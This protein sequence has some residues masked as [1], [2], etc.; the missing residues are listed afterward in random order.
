MSVRY[1]VVTKLSSIYYNI[2]DCKTDSLVTERSRNKFN[3]LEDVELS[4]RH[5]G[6]A[7]YH[8]DKLNEK[9]EGR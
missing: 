9:E 3:V 4:Y 2:L 5:I 1:V 6:S 7:Q 8:A